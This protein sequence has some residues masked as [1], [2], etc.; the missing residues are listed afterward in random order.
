[1]LRHSPFAP[2]ARPPSRGSHTPR[3]RP[4]V[5]LKAPATPQSQLPF[6]SSF[7]LLLGVYPVFPTCDD[8]R[9][10][11]L[12]AYDLLAGLPEGWKTPRM[13]IGPEPVFS[14]QCTSSG[15]RWKQDPA[16]SGNELPPTWAIPSP[17]TT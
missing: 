9:A 17:A 13:C 5:R 1:M 11:L 4:R 10:Y 12:S 7:D 2:S 6:S 3:L 8:F 15:G 14:M 16:C